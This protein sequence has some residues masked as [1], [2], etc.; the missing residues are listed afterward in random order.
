[1]IVNNVLTS[2]LLTNCKLLTVSARMS[3]LQ[4]PNKHKME[5]IKNLRNSSI[6]LLNLKKIIN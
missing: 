6:I 5:V 4:Y 1:M 2:G 3:L